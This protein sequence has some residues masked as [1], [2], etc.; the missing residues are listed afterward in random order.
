[1]VG[2]RENILPMDEFISSV[3]AIPKSSKAIFECS[4]GL[5]A[6]ADGSYLA[7]DLNFYFAPIGLVNDYED[8]DIIIRCRLSNSELLEIRTLGKFQIL[9][10]SIFEDGHVNVIMRFKNQE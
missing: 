7:S 1:M 5:Y 9:N 6:V 2:T 10:Q 8:N 4:D 3:N